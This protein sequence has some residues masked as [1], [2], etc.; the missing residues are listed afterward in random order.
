[1]PPHLISEPLVPEGGQ[2]ATPSAGGEPPLPQRFR[3]RD[4]ALTVRQILRTWRSTKNDR[5]DTYLKRHWFEIDCEC[6]ARAVVYF[7]RAAL[8]GKP[9]WWLYT[10]DGDAL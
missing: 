1:M 6:G 4:R 2:Y 9:R 8:R 10:I 5:G 3:W 7:D